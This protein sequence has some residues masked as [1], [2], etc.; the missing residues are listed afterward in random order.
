[1]ANTLTAFK[2]NNELKSK[3][4]GLEDFLAAYEFANEDE[5]REGIKKT[6]TTKADRIDRLIK[7]MKQNSK[8]KSK[9]QKSNSNSTQPQAANYKSA[10]EDTMT[11]PIPYTSVNVE[12]LL[13]TA[14]TN[15]Q[16]YEEAERIKA[17]NN[18]PVVTV[19]EKVLTDLKVNHVDA[20]NFATV[21]VTPKNGGKNNMS[22]PEATNVEE[23]IAEQNAVNT[24]AEVPAEENSNLES[25][26][27]AAET[28]D[29]ENE[30]EMLNSK[31]QSINTD[32]DESERY[33]KKLYTER[34]NNSKAL[35]DIVEA[36]KRIEKTLLYQKNKFEN[37]YAQDVQT[38]ANLQSEKDKLKQL[39]QDKE[40]CLSKI[41]E[42]MSISLYCGENTD[43]SFDYDV[44]NFEIS[45]ADIT[46]KFTSFFEGDLDQTN[47]L[48]E[49]SVQEL[50]KVARIIL[51][52]EQIEQKD[53]SKVD[54]HFD[55][56][57]NLTALLELMGRKVIIS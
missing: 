46:A 7:Q 48:D 29:N 50:K 53:G 17:E 18:K 56:H 9:L 20:K 54:L 35:D 36:I 28:T 12:E 37:V 10:A 55:D 3:K 15:I 47:L 42:L 40:D 52:A 1:M 21:A 11:T 8:Q 31:L 2:L 6:I 49:F 27:T 4:W 22:N 41:R 33:I 25:T 13:Q 45:A 5:L 26:V 39:Q 19:S 23:P 51:V 16:K 38:T 34:R 30:L 14:E 57:S 44:R 24:V 32:I 43:K